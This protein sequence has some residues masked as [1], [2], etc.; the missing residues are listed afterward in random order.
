[1]ALFSRLEGKITTLESRINTISFSEP[2]PALPEKVSP[3]ALDALA[4]HDGLPADYSAFI[5]I[6]RIA[7]R[8]A[9]SPEELEHCQHA[10]DQMTLVLRDSAPPTPE[11]PPSRTPRSRSRSP[12]SQTPSRPRFQTQ[13]GR[14]FYVAR[15]GKKYDISRPPPYP[16]KECKENHWYWES[17]SSSSTP[18]RQNSRPVAPRRQAA[19][20]AT[21]D[22]DMQ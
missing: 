21:M 22:A 1:V 11:E 2:L 8:A 7:L 3:E 18:S 20:G 16:C 15:S 17:C 10:Y 5:P 13:N 12:N 9:A 14:K 6:L 4:V 19:T